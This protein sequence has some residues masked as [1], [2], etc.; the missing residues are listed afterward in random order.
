[1][2][3][4]NQ[5]SI[6]LLAAREK[7][8]GF[9]IFIVAVFVVTAFSVVFAI[10]ANAQKPL[11]SPREACQFYQNTWEKGLI[12]VVSDTENECLVRVGDNNTG[13]GYTRYYYSGNKLCVENSGEYY[14]L[15]SPQTQ[16]ETISQKQQDI[17][18]KIVTPPTKQPA[19]Q[20]AVQPSDIEESVSPTF[21]NLVKALDKILS[22]LLNV[23]YNILNWI[24]GIF[25]KK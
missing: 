7:N 6:S 8:P 9:A 1:M 10:H 21:N 5:N 23:L 19:V 13:F 22:G 24:F 3:T 18:G 20:P 15:S 25:S 14:G 11:T 4:N 16:C 17:P 12:S 2:K